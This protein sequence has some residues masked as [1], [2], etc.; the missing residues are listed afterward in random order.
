MV[1]WSARGRARADAQGRGDDGA[2]SEE[3]IG[4]QPSG[5]RKVLRGFCFF[6]PKEMLF[7]GGVSE[8]LRPWA[9]K[10]EEP[11]GR[12]CPALPIDREP[13]T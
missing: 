13:L 3:S 8:E 1:D 11:P 9:R 6:A 7:F 10:R 5:A 12:F 4:T 2:G